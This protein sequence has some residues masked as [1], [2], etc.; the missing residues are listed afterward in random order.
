MLL[1]TKIPAIYAVLATVIGVLLLSSLRRPAMGPPHDMVGHA[2]DSNGLLFARESDS[3]NSTEDPEPN[4]FQSTSFEDRSDCPS[5]PASRAARIPDSST[6]ATPGRRILPQQLAAQPPSA[7]LDDASPPRPTIPSWRHVPYRRGRDFDYADSPSICLTNVPGFSPRDGVVTRSPL[8]IADLLISL[9]K[10]S[11]GPNG[12]SPGRFVEIGTR[13]G[14]IFACVSH[15]A[16]K[17]SKVIEAGKRMYCP[18]LAERGIPHICSDYELLDT[19][20]KFPEGE[21]YYFWHW[22]EEIEHMI[23]HVI[24]IEQKRARKGR[25][26]V[27][28]SNFEVQ[29]ATDLPLREKMAERYGGTWHKVFFDEGDGERQFGVH[30]PGVFDLEELVAKADSGWLEELKDNWVIPHK[31]NPELF[32]ETGKLLDQD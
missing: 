3:L 24:R 26:A 12:S 7:R 25:G 32:D 19:P 2:T 15:F 29:F 30:W 14:D 8:V 21:V 1:S 23:R 5:C 4:I 22:P 16:A 20:E 18:V 10:N 31:K 27:I 9:V 11:T 17:G 6:T 28:V 13:Q